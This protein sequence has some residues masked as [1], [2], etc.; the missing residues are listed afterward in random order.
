[1]SRLMF[2]ACVRIVIYTTGIKLSIFWNKFSHTLNWANLFYFFR[3]KEYIDPCI[4][5]TKIKYK[6]LILYIC[7]MYHL[8]GLDG[9]E[10]HVYEGSFNCC[11]LCTIISKFQWTT[12]ATFEQHQTADGKNVINFGLCF[13]VIYMSFF[14]SLWLCFCIILQ[15]P[16]PTTSI[17][18]QSCIR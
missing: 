9:P 3:T 15:T 7:L 1:M 14:G 11:L 6:I 17:Y 4:V 18:K 12:L 16:I 13:W 5:C 10:A 8:Q 2:S